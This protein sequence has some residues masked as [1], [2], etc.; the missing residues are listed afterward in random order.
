MSNDERTYGGDD[1][2]RAF[3]TLKVSALRVGLF[4]AMAVFFASF[5]PPALFAMTVSNLLF[6]TAI[7]STVMAVLIGEA[8]FAK[9][10]TRWDEAAVLVGTA[11]I[12]GFFVDP[13]AVQSAMAELPAADG[14]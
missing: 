3:P 4:L 1:E 7:V 9:R 5:M 12:A 6:L 14:S 13:A 11:L 10:P 8:P 2:G